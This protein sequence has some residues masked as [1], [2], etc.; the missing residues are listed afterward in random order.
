MAL[1]G[2]QLLC[3]ESEEI[4]PGW[5]HVNDSDLLLITDDF[6]HAHLI[7]LDYLS[8]AKVSLHCC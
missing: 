3:D 1:S 5:F 4:L 7:S 6:F 2:S 8:K